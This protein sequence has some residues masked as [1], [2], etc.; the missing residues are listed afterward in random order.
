M[1]LDE[2][3]CQKNKKASL[4]YST[5]PEH[6]IALVWLLLWDCVLGLLKYRSVVLHGNVLCPGNC[7]YRLCKV[8]GYSVKCGT[9]AMR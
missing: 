7:G 1:S 4:I 5:K 2:F 8:I 6:V 3:L 9:S